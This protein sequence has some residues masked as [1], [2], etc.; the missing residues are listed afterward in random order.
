MINFDKFARRNVY[1]L[2]QRHLTI[3]A[4]VMICP[5]DDQMVAAK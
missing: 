2:Y 3:G 4:T 5:D 1:N